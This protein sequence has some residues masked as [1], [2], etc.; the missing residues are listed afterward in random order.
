MP[1]GYQ[2]TKRDLS[3]TDPS[4]MNINT[5]AGRNG[6]YSQATAWFLID[7]VAVSFKVGKISKQA[8][9]EAKI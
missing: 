2:I 5:K 7:A 4:H 3:E 1:G 6:T 8:R 9:T